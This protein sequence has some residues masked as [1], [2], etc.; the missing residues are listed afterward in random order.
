MFKNGT[1]DV[2]KLQARKCNRITGSE[3]VITC[4]DWGADLNRK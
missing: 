1:D 3:N 4:F 2:I